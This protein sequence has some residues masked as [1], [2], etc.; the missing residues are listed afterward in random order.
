MDAD[1]SSGARVDVAV[2]GGGLS[3]LVAASRLHES[4][5]S[6]VVLEAT[7]EVGGRTISRLCGGRV[8]DLGG[9][10]VGRDYVRLRRLVSSLGLHLEP[11]PRVPRVR[12]RPEV[13]PP[14]EPASL[15]RLAIVA[16]KLGKLSRALSAE[17]PWDTARARELDTLSL[18]DWLEANGI[19]D[20]SAR[21]F[22]SV[23]RTF[24]TADPERL[25]MLHLLVW[26]RPAGGMW[27][28]TRETQWRIREGAQ[29][30][31]K[32]LSGRIGSGRIVLEAPVVRVEQNPDDGVAVYSEDGRC[33][34]ARHVVV[35]VPLATTR[36]IDFQPALPEEQLQLLQEVSSPSITKLVA[37]PNAQRG[38]NLVA[39]GDPLLPLAYR[40]PY[41]ALSFAY[42][43]NADLPRDR[44]KARLL[45]IVDLAENGVED[46]ITHPWQ[47]Q[48]YAKGGYVAFAPGQLTRHGPALRSG[49]GLVHFAGADRS[50]WPGTMEGAVADGQRIA[51]RLLKTDLKA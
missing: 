24:T 29:E 21:L 35:C 18:A 23:A 26:T 47:E 32:R 41:H 50:I 14:L 4:G 27:A 33:W 37:A 48:P 15:A 51:T 20:C 22:G 11:T 17:A 19:D 49:H 12:T 40:D 36:G 1:F 9:E 16:R 25:S 45:D 10:W 13:R 6:T 7:G 8:V 31:C 3:G 5:H 42:E 43:Q 39:V 2:V 34:H 30:T 44:L 46:F 38:K 28:L